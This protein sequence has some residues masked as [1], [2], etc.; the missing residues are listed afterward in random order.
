MVQNNNGDSVQELERV[1]IGSID[2][3][4]FGLAKRNKRK[5][6]FVTISKRLLA[7]ALQ[8]VPQIQLGTLES[9]LE[10]IWQT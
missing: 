2:L 1:D 8:G 6:T 4:I 9:F 7:G 10:R 3:D 5:L